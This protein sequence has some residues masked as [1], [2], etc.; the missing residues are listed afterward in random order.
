MI[1]SINDGSVEP[2]II[3]N[4]GTNLPDYGSRYLLTNRI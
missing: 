1:I 2:I 4:W 3:V